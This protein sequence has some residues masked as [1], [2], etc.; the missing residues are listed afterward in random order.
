MWSHWYENDCFSLLQIK[1]IF[2]IR[3]RFKSDWVIWR[4]FTSHQCGLG[5]SNSGPISFVGWV[6]CWFSPL[7]CSETFFFWH[8]EFSYPKKDS[9]VFKFLSICYRMG[10]NSHEQPL[11]GCATTKS[12]LF[13]IFLQIMTWLSWKGRPREGRM[14][15][16]DKLHAP[17]RAKIFRLC[18]K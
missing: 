10:Y 16:K 5:C 3:L 18:N 6:C 8:S 9:T 4:A 14:F 7:A 2:T 17:M 13:I 12:S 1:L 11:C 15:F